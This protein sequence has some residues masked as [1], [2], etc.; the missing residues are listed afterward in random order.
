MLQAV[1]RY[2][3]WLHTGWPAGGV[4][5]LPVVNDDG[6]TNVPGVWVVGDLTGVPLLKLSAAG[7]ARVVRRIAERLK[8]DRERS[9]N[10]LIIVGAGVSGA[11]AALEARRLGLK[12]RLLEA[13][14]PFDTIVNFPVGKPIYTYPRGEPS[15]SELRF[16]DEV[17]PREVLLEDLREQSSGLA[18]EKA[19]VD[20]IE[21]VAGRLQVVLENGERLKASQV[22]VAIG[23]SGNF[24]KLN[25]PG[26]DLPKVSNRLHDPREF[27][28]KDVLVVGGGDG[29][30]ETAI[31]LAES[32]G[33]V[34]LSYRKPELSRVKPD[35][36]ERLKR[37]EGKIDLRLNTVVERILPS[38]VELRR[39]DGSVESVPNEAVFTM[40]GREAPLEFF[41][42]SGI[43]VHGDRGWWWWTSLGVFL[44]FCVW[45]YH[46]KK[47]GVV[48][49]GIPPLD[50]WIDIGGWWSAKGWFPAAVPEWLASLGETWT[51]PSSL[52]GTLGM[53][54]GE[55]GFYYSLAY[56][57]CVLIFGM[58]RIARRRTPYVSVQTWTLA[59]IQIIPLFF[60]PYVLLPWMGHNGWFEQGAGRWI[61]DQLFPV[62]D[63]GH[64]REYW[65]AFGLVLAWP[66][67]LWNVFADQPLT[68]WLVL[69]FLQT[70]V[71]IPVLVYFWGKGAY[72]GWIC[73]CGALAETMGDAHRS[74]MPHGRLWNR[75]NL[76]GQVFLLFA[77][78]LLLL[79]IIGWVWPGSWAEGAFKYLLSGLPVLNYAWFVDL[80]FAGILGVGLYFWFS[81]RVWCRFA[82]PLAALMHIYARFGRFRILADKKKCISCN[83]CTSVCHQGIDVMSFAN[84]GLP[85]ADPQCVRCSACVQMCPT[86]VLQ[87]GQTDRAGRVISTDR[88]RASVVQV[89]GVRGTPLSWS[90]RSTPTNG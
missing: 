12:F 50:R 48:V 39:A 41:R 64:G 15:G 44:A 43:R 9:I 83:V 53:S 27:S 34:T 13:G 35:N 37:L 23:R 4:E 63:Y 88:L 20:R 33:Q 11:S 52:A 70:F 67:F 79:R 59:S 82:C 1:V 68:A 60:L 89:V 29:A 40:I 84:K 49:T 55:P 14:V 28:G 36:V 86:G 73:S 45:L 74:K 18:V 25:V 87:F 31:A 7:G 42:R 72:C 75:L 32:G 57:L 6:S 69:S 19:R 71:L 62:A 56:C 85:M 61:A 8:S 2:A 76:I 10:D 3:R 38:A 58:K 46:W 65:R 5:P 51:D 16:R 24:R 26:E 77:F 21:R 80:F 90:D 81:G 30:V 22:I 54:L 78:V 66:L 47:A 17:H